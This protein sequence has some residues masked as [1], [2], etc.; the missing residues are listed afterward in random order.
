MNLKNLFSLLKFNKKIRSIIFKVKRNLRITSFM[1]Q[2]HCIIIVNRTNLLRY[3][4]RNALITLS[5]RVHYILYFVIKILFKYNLFHLQ[6]SILFSEI[7]LACIHAD[8]QNRVIT[9]HKWTV[10]V[11]RR[12]SRETPA[13]CR[14]ANRAQPSRGS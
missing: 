3:N 5:D 12:L 10:D 7:C 4:R 14:H 13:V 6:C 9:R 8:Q 11:C 2:Q 1:F